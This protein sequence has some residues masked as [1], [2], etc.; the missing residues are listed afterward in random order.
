MMRIV[1]LL[2]V[3]IMNDREH[4]RLYVLDL[5]IQPAILRVQLVTCEHGIAHLSHD[6]TARMERGF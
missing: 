6:P 3:I 1:Q 5:D 2:Y 4:L